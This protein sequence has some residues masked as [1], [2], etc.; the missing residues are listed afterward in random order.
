[1]S[2]VP[3]RP[4][5]PRASRRCSRRS[6]RWAEHLRQHCRVSKADADRQNAVAGFQAGPGVPVV[7]HFMHLD[8]LHRLAASVEGAKA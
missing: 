2:A 8:H 4:P 1:M 3:S 6:S 7:R 5:L